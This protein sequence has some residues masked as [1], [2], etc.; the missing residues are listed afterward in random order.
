M[1]KYLEKIALNAS[2]AREMAKQVGI[3]PN[4]L[5]QWK[6]GLRQ[7]RKGSGTPLSGEALEKAKIEL[8]A[9]N[10][11]SFKA[12][13]RKQ[14]KNP[15]NELIFSIGQKGQL[16]HKVRVGGVDST[17]G[18]YNVWD[19]LPDNTSATRLGHSHQMYTGYPAELRNSNISMPSGI[20]DNLPFKK[21]S[22]QDVDFSDWVY[23]RTLSDPRLSNREAIDIIKK[24]TNTIV[25]KYIEGHGLIGGTL[26]SGRDVALGI[27][28]PQK[29]Q[30]GYIR[31]NTANIVS[32]ELGVDAVHK[33]TGLYNSKTG[34]IH[35]LKHRTIMFKH[36]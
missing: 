19:K 6:Y 11:D 33:S 29:I 34:L 22:I 4:H 36:E 21:R 26:G 2:K 30:N 12:I 35:A 5:T 14:S 31:K 1:N 24:H 17:K 25:G 9:I 16:T 7:L 28:F 27:G 8:G 10:K 20:Q 3:V 15:E 23:N 32:P 13:Q 18:A